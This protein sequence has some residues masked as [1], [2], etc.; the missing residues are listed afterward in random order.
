[1]LKHGYHG[2]HHHLS[3]KHLHRYV[4][5]FSGRH[6]LR[7]Q[8]TDVVMQNIFVGLTGKS[9]M[10]KILFSYSIAVQLLRG[11]EGLLSCPP[12]RTIP[13]ANTLR[14]SRC[15]GLPVE[16]NSLNQRGLD[17]PC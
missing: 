4:N 7:P 5:E 15:V 3:I 17:H 6:N 8:D 11:F 16:Y 1:M 2:T 12:H 13:S 10:Y 9:F 14:E